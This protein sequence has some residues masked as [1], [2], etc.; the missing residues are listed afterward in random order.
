MRR[1]LEVRA[2]LELEQERV[3]AMVY[4]PPFTAHVIVQSKQPKCHG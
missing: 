1:L 3:I 4:V 2:E